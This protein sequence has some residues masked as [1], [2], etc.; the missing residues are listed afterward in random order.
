MNEIVIIGGGASALMLAALLPPK[1]VTI[2]EANTK[3]GAKIQVSGGG[4]CNITNQ[5][6]DAAYY[7]G[8]EYFI[9]PAL[10]M[11]DEK[12][13]LKWLEERGLQPVLRKGTQYFC[14]NSSK[15]ILSIFQKESSKQN[16]LLGEK[17]TSVT[18]KAHTFEVKT[19]KR[20]LKAEKVVVASGGLSYPQLKAS[21]IG[22]RIAEAF[23]HQIIKTSPALVGFTLQ[24]EEFF[25]KELSGAST[26]VKVTVGEK[27]IQGSL[28][29]AHKGISGPVVLNASLYWEKGKIEIDFLGDVDWE[30]LTRSEKNISSL[31]PM[32]KRVTK[33][34]LLQL[35]LQDKQG[36]KVTSSE[37]ERLKSLCHYSFAPAGTFGYSKAEVT[38]GGVSTDEVNAYTMM[39]EKEEGLYFIGEV[40]DVTGRLGGYNF[41]WAFSTAYVC[42]QHLING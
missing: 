39:S 11:F 3:L 22:Y 36:K 12:M 14:P 13:L 38:K 25:F 7:L 18:K 23:G 10:D 29:F 17:V 28:L 9:Q 40:L 15:E 8:E 27:V 6:M 19:D 21:D 34:F 30:T 5:V 16:I 1:S 24:P 41:Q 4:K 37:L 42:H 20:V 2:I 32:P 31:L 33:R 26:E 35:G